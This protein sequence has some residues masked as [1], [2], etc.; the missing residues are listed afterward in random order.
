[1]TSAFP[2]QTP[3]DYTPSEQ[4][5]LTVRDDSQSEALQALSSGTAQLVLRTLHN[6]PKPASEVAE[7]VGTSI[8]NAQYHLTQLEEN[9]LVKSVDTWYSPKGTEMTV[10]APTAQEFVVRFGTDDR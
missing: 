2:T 9:G 7:T 10:Y 4:T 8:Q 6:K 1:M 5:H 3:V